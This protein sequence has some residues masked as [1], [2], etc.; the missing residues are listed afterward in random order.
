MWEVDQIVGLKKPKKVHC[1]N[2]KIT[3]ETT[4]A[5]P[6]GWEDRREARANEPS[7]GGGVP[8]AAGP[9][10]AGGTSWASSG[11]QKLEIR[12][13]FCCQNDGLMLG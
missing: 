6:W 11:D 12:S 10:E 13:S 7:P 9:C 4:V 3:L 8:F 2:T 5:T 1:G